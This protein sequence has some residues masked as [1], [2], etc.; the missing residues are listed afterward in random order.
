MPF[1][2]LTPFW[3]SRWARV[4][5]RALSLAFALAAVSI[6]V[7]LVNKVVYSFLVIH[8]PVKDG[9]PPTTPIHDMVI[10]FLVFYSF[11]P[12]HCSTSVQIEVVALYYNLCH[13]NTSPL[14]SSHTPFFSVKRCPDCS[15]DDRCKH[16]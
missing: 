14:S 4:W 16:K 1:Q 2:Y 15:H 9:F 12:W 8:L 13:F 10:G 11:C 5:C 3:L 7:K 6:S